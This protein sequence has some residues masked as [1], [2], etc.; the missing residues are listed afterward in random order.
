MSDASAID[1][2]L[3]GP[4]GLFAIESCPVDGTAWQIPAVTRPSRSAE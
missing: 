2:L 3:L 1:H 4:R